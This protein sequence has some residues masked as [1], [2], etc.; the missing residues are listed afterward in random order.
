MPPPAFQL[1]KSH[2]LWVCAARDA[3]VQCAIRAW[4]AAR[5]TAG[6]RAPLMLPRCST[7]SSCVVVQRAPL[8]LQLCSA[9]RSWCSGTALDPRQGAVQL[10]AL[11]EQR[12][13]S[14]L[15]MQRA[16]LAQQQSRQ[17]SSHCIGAARTAR[18]AL[19][20]LHRSPVQRLSACGCT[21]D[22]CSACAYFQSARVTRCAAG[23]SLSRGSARCSWCILWCNR[24][25]RVVRRAAMKL[26]PLTVERCVMHPR[27]AE[28]QVVMEWCW[29]RRSRIV[30]LQKCRL[31]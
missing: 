18:R 2:A 26:A 27:R 1:P 19:M 13:S 12:C 25:E 30:A 20:Q 4:A 24:A 23:R 28:A 3:V 10:T 7:R 14:R 16:P 11:A 31:H 21:A 5:G 29:M 8:A 22:T 17:R 9:S 6:P 15:V